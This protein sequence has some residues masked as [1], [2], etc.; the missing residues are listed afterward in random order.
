MRGGLALA[1]AA[2]FRRYPFRGKTAIWTRLEGHVPRGTYH[3]RMAGG[4]RMEIDARLYWQRQMLAACY[5]RAQAWA[6][7]ALL[8]P[9]ETFIDGGANCGYFSCLAAGRVGPAGK[10]IAFEPDARLEA[11]LTRQSE[12]NGR[13]IVVETV[14]LSNGERDAPFHTHRTDSEGWTIGL[15]SLEQR[16]DQDARL[17]RTTSLDSYLAQAGV[18]HVRLAKLDLEGHEHAAIEGAA[19]SL[20]GGSIENLCVEIND[21][22]SAE[23]LMATPWE[24]M[25]RIAPGWP[26]VDAASLGRVQADVLCLRGEGLRRWRHRRA[27]AALV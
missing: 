25:I 24:A 18:A 8:A 2:A 26:P 12:L 20:A 9:G 23:A 1:A 16:A 3:V 14:A 17:V 11:Q 7:R 19:R 27:I 6:L 5:E 10:V 22:R 13:R 21:R 15:G 4:G